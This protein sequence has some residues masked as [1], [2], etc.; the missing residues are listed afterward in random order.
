MKPESK[1]D[2]YNVEFV[3]GPVCGEAW[4]ISQCLTTIYRNY[5]DIH[6]RKVELVYNFRDTK[7]V[8]GVVMNYYSYSAQRGIFE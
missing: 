5:T 7:T 6:G 1:A 3:G 4:E 2:V 8:S